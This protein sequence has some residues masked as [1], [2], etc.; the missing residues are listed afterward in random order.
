M[1]RLFVNN[2]KSNE[3]LDLWQ[4]VVRHV[5]SRNETRRH[6][7]QGQV[8]RPPQVSKLNEVPVALLKWDGILRDYL[9]AG[10]KMPSYDDRRA[11]LLNIL[12]QK[13][14]E[15]VFLRIPGMQE[16][17]QDASQEEQGRAYFALRA[18]LQKQVDMTTQ[19]AAMGGGLPGGGVHVLPEAPAADRRCCR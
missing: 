5:R 17:M 6:E 19:W 16:S 15:E 1:A 18:Q 9:E 12:P 13:F 7:L 2:S 4:K 11:A 14:K 3:G 10:G 8:Q